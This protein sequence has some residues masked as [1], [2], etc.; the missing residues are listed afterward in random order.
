MLP[1]LLA[2]CAPLLAA[3]A[4]APAVGAATNNIFTAAGNGTGAFGGDG[5]LATDAQIHQP[6]G[7]AVT[8]DGGFLIADR[9]NDR[10]RRVS[11]TGRITTAAGTGTPG[12]SGDDNSATA[13][14]LSLPSGVAGTADGGYLIA[15]QGNQRVR[16]VSPGGT[17][18]TVAGTGMPGFSGDDGAATTAQLNNPVGVAAAADGSFLIADRDNHRV[19]RVSPAGTITTV[20][21]SGSPGFSGDD[22]AATAA[23]LDQPAGVAAAADGGFLIADTNNHRVRRV[24]PG[25]TITTVAGVGTSA[26]TRDGGPAVAAAIS[27][28][29]GVAAAPDGGFLIADQ[30]NH[31][32][33]RVSPA[34]TITTVA[35]VGTNAFSGD[36]GPAIAAELNAPWAVAAPK[37]GGFLIADRVNNRVRFVDAE[38]RR[39]GAGP[40]GSPG[41]QGPTGDQG[42]RGG[43]TLI[44]RLLLAVVDERLRA[45][46]RRA[47]TLRYLA[48]VAAQVE[49]RVLKGRRRLASVRRQARAGRNWLRLRAPRA[50]GRYRVVLEAR[51]NDGQRATAAVALTVRRGAR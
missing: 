36:A 37:G 51:G 49:L 3:L 23:Q 46:S 40:Q 38:W 21:G 31:R 1:R 28:P 47:V 45:R 33:R 44:D 29:T 26:F 2:R 19:R 20:A 7:V 30:G 11:P 25:G 8:A 17:I 12:F 4:L 42:V 41:I 43:T 15:D 32:V 5:L 10:V 27:S 50:P 39:P 22:G 24:S 14:Q 13:A 18:T 35:G 6:T 34:G 48:T 16:R 9:D